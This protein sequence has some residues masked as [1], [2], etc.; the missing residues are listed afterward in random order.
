MR[1]EHRREDP[2]K[3][4]KPQRKVIQGRGAHY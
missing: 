3:R 2:E 1:K 4:A